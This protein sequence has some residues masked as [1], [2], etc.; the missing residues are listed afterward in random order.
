[1]ALKSRYATKAEIPEGQ[2]AFYVEKDGSF[3]LDAD[4]SDHPALVALRDNRD[5][6]LGEKKTT[7]RER[8]E[9]R[10]ALDQVKTLAGIADVSELGNVL[11]G[12]QSQGKE[13]LEK[14]I[15]ERISTMKA[16]WEKKEKDW[17][18]KESGYQGQLQTLLIDNA[19]TS[20]ATKAGIQPTAMQDVLLRGRS[21]YRL[22]DGKP[23]PMAEGDKVIYGKDGVN[24]MPVSE[25]LGRLTTEAPHLFNPSQGGGA[26]PGEGG[27]AALPAGS[28]SRA[29]QKGF[30]ANLD[31]VAKGEISVK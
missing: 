3:V 15:A 10:A 2:A 7:Q 31:K 4:L 26:K 23:V 22:V 8:D 14:A 24:P 16:E 25:W 6:I 18:T 29:D 1:V 20:E 12:K 27:R 30:L 17:H 19:I 21:L 13:D 5:T 28:I 11:K 9:A